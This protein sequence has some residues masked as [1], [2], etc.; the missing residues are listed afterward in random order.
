MLQKTDL[1]EKNTILMLVYGLAANLGGVAQLI[2]GPPIGIVLSLFIP[3]LVT[4]GV[5]LLQRKIEIVRPYFPFIV[6][7]TGTITIY[8]CIVTN[9][10]TLATIILSFFILIM[11]TI[12][13]KY[14]VLAAECICNTMFNDTSYR[15]PSPTK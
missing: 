7:I 15:S 8:V 11:S 4:L 10:V 13:S 14:S 9:E 5:Y 3:A 2:I 6:T 12:H 1:L